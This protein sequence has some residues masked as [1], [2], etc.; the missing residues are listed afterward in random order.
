MLAGPGNRKSAPSTDHYAL[1]RRHRQPVPYL[2]AVLDRSSLPKGSSAN[3]LAATHVRL[4][5]K[6][7]GSTARET[8][9]TG[10]YLGRA[11]PLLLSYACRVESMVAR[12]E[13]S[14]QR[15]E[16]TL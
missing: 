4:Q 12:P 15:L 8:G 14:F 2:W 13:K 5:F 11:L 3:R 6:I 10:V 7:L 9:V 1:R 16:R